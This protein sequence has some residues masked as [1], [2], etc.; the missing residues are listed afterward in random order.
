MPKNIAAK[1]WVLQPSY[2]GKRW[3][4]WPGGN[5]PAPGGS[6]ATTFDALYDPGFALTALDNAA[7]TII[8]RPAKTANLATP[9]YTDPV[10]GTKVWRLGDATTES[11]SPTSEFLRHD[12]SRRA[13]FSAQNKHYLLRGTAGWYFIFDASTFQK[14]SGPGPNGGFTLL[15][16]DD[17]E[18][19]WHPTDP[20]KLW[21]W[22]ADLSWRELNVTTGVSTVLF[23]LAGRLPWPQATQLWTKAEGCPS[24][25]GRYFGLMATRYDAAAQQN[26]VYGLV[27]YDRVTDTIV[28]TLDASAF[29]GAFPDHISMSAGG[30]YVVP[31]WAFTPALGTRAYTRDFASFTTLHTQSEHSDLGFGPN[32]EE[33][34]VYTDYGTGFIVARNMANGAGINL[35]QIYPAGGVG[36][37]AHISCKCFDKPGWCV[38]STYADTS[39]YG[40]AAPAVPQYG[41]FRKI[42]A[43]ELKAGGRVLN[44]AHTRTNN[45]YGGYYGEPQAT[46][47]RDFSRVVWT[48]NFQGADTGRIESFMVGLPSWAIPST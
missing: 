36:Y 31:S 28:G 2:D 32:G 11:T 38:V 13:A 42:M 23:N 4:A 1:S 41:M 5:R 9:G 10:Y 16:G 37:A 15:S 6:T 20:D 19:I 35:L 34:Y 24:A 26:I 22:G 33:M 30:N 21:H 14:V 25:D 17:S 8:S 7:Q 47:N 18:P 27:C 39:N 40:A 48:S 44:I 46:V 12:Y 3:S 29:G 43:V 45:N